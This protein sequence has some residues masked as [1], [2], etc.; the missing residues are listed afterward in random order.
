M[1]ILITGGSG[2]IGSNYINFLFKDDKNVNIVNIDALYYCANNENINEEVRNSDR[3]TFIK[4][5]M[6]D[7][8]LLVKIINE[9]KI[10]HIIH[11][12][13]QSHVDNSFN[14]SLKYTNDNVLG[15]HTLLEAIKNTNKNIILLHFST[16]EV[17]GESELNESEKTEESILCPTNPY[18]ASKA[19]A[20]MYVRSYIHSFNLKIIITRCNNVFGKNQ[21]PE[22]L[23]PKF[24]NML[25]NNQKCTIHG[26]G[27]SIRNF[28]HVY[29]VCTAI[30]NIL[31]YGT[32]GEIYN[33]GSDEKWE[34]S[35]LDITKIL[36]KKIKKTDN[37]NDYIEYV[38]DRPFNDK[39]YFISNQKLK[40]LDWEQIKIFDLE[41]DN[42]IDEKLVDNSYGFIIK[43]N[44]KDEES[45]KMWIQLYNKIREYSDCEI[46]F[47]CSSVL[48]YVK[49]D[50]KLVNCKIIKNKFD[51]DNP[52]ISY[53]YYYI[54]N[55]FDK[56]IIIDDS[57]NINI[58]KQLLSNIRKT[59]FLNISKKDQIN[60]SNEIQLLT[61]LLEKSDDKYV[62]LNKYKNKHLWNGSN[63]LLTI[64]TLKNIK[65]IQDKFNIFKFNKNVDYQTIN[66]IEN[67]FG[68]L[69][70]IYQ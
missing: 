40:D 12:A 21:Y 6:C 13:A 45:N 44:V 32:F 36:V 29:D 22:K 7:Y 27:E 68:F 54:N 65:Q 34:K 58:I 30:K 8:E 33:I 25:K 18:S 20:E 1:N 55:F 24:I 62:I 28:I 4:G 5:N 9:H 15:T 16:D 31:N 35:V 37:Y 60:N 42:L 19:A 14:E 11:F 2:F 70:S 64:A 17:Y 23:V 52:L 59:N 61:S 67:I 57:I 38:N 49:F 41:I 50:K 10:S 66:I 56:A 26:K 69:L 39:R 46:I 53:Y 3:Y 51:F 63:R 43:R 48:S 47:I